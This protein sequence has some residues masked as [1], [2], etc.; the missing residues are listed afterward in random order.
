M[1]KKI[2]PAQRRH[3]D[4]LRRKGLK[5]GHAYE[6]R[7]I[8]ARRKEVTRV[9]NLCKEF[10]TGVWEDV[11]KTNLSEDYLFDWYK[12]LY[13]DAGLPRCKSTA[14]DLSQGKAT[15]EE[16]YW[17]GELTRYA[18]DRAGSEIVFVEGT[19]KDSLVGI[20]RQSMADNPEAGIEKLTRIIA[21]GYQDIELWQARR[22]AQTET[23]IGMADAGALA[24]STLDVNFVKQWAISGLGNTRETH[25]AMDGIIVGADE[26]FTLPEGDLMMYPHDGSMGASAGEII[27]CAC[28]C[29]RIPK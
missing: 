23:M 2:T 27:N 12:G 10:G 6:A 29:I 14:R 15:P 18:E 22:I 3:M 19:L 11:I 1:R 16:D 21:K 8:K 9:L 26:P 5:V 7:L 13:L 4:Y 24:A 25:E 20:V 28:D 17:L